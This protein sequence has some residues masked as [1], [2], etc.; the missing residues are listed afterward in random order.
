MARNP[1]DDLPQVPD[2][3]LTSTDLS[4]G[5]TLATPQLSGIFGAGGQDVSPQLSWSGAPEGTASYVV[6]CYDPDAP[7]VSGFWHWA[8]FNIPASTTELPTGAGDEGGAGLPDGAVQLPNDASLARY[9]GSAPPAGHGPHRYYFTVH[10]LD[11]P[12]LDVPATATPV[13]LMF[14]TF[15]RV[16]GRA[17]ILGT[18]ANLG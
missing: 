2:F 15:G 5:G 8:V 6:T 14:N 4:D 3:T 7:T 16:L 13:F 18:Y 11:V 10:A 12:S 17:T 9:L 1:Y